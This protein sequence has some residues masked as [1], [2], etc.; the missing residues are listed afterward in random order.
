MGRLIFPTGSRIYLDTAPI[1]YSVEKHPEY[2]YILQDL[3]AS[4]DRSEIE[5]VSSELTLLEALV[6][7]AREKNEAGMKDYEELL[8]E[9]DLQLVPISTSILKM[10]VKLRADLNL[11]TPDSIHAATAVLTECDHIISND[12]GLRRLTI[13]SVTILSDLI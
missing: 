2:W 7:P 9:S 13:P 11:K 4:A 6:L 5:I 12:H 8:M 1:I 10:A 3:W